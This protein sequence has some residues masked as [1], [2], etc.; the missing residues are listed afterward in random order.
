VGG[1]LAGFPAS[2]PQQRQHRNNAGAAAM[3]TSVM[4]G[5]GEGGGLGWQP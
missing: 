1:A 5:A 4:A 3:L 2:A